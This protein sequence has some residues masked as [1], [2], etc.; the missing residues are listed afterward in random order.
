M[1][2]SIEASCWRCELVLFLLSPA[3]AASKWCLAEFL[4][5]KSLNK[6]IFAAIVAPTLYTE[7][8]SEMTTEWQLIDLT[9]GP[10]DYCA[11]VTMSPS[12]TVEAVSFGTD[13]TQQAT[14]W[15]S[16]GWP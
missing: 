1:A 11:S 8:P 3:W 9:A 5:A 2:G 14:D 16:P 7:L 12:N 6:R 4:L 13:G 10:R 15:T